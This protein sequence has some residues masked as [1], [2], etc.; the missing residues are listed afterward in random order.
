M[1]KIMVRLK[2]ECNNVYIHIWRDKEWWKLANALKNIPPKIGNNLSISSF[3]EH[4][5]CILSNTC[6]E[7][8]F[9]WTMPNFADPILDDPFEMSELLFVLNNVK[10]N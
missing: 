3:Y 10:E 8:S 9:D 1:I 7:K 6:N 5:K 2:K 4:F